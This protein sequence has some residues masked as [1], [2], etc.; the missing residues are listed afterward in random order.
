MSS[1]RW[2]KTW[3]PLGRQLAR[4]GLYFSMNSLETAVPFD[5]CSIVSAVVWGSSL[6]FYARLARVCVV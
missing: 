3:K 2:S 1:S 5:F 6:A 4:L